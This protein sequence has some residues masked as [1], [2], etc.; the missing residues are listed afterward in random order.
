MMGTHC[1]HVILR[2]IFG[3][4]YERAISLRTYRHASAS[5]QDC[6]EYERFEGSKI[7]NSS[8]AAQRAREG[9]PVFYF[10]RLGLYIAVTIVGDFVRRLTEKNTP[11][12]Y[13]MLPNDTPQ[14]IVLCV[15]HP[16]DTLTRAYISGKF[17][18]YFSQECHQVYVE[19]TGDYFIGG[20]FTNAET[21]QNCARR[22][23]GK[24]EESN[25]V[26]WNVTFTLTAEHSYDLPVEQQLGGK[27][28]GV[29]FYTHAFLPVQLAELIDSMRNAYV[30]AKK[31]SRGG[32][33]L[34]DIASPPS[35]A[36]VSTQMPTQMPTQ[37]PTQ[38]P[39]QVST[40][41]PTQMP[42]QVTSYR[43]RTDI[44]TDEHLDSM[45][46]A[47][48]ADQHTERSSTHSPAFDDFTPPESASETL[49]RLLAEIS[50]GPQIVHNTPVHATAHSSAQ[51]SMHTPVHS[52]VHATAHSSAHLSSHGI[53]APASF[54]PAPY[55][56]PTIEPVL[57]RPNELIM[58]WIARNPPDLMACAQYYDIYVAMKKDTETSRRNFDGLV[59]L[60]GFRKRRIRRE[61]TWVSNCALTQHLTM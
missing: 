41:M 6:A 59:E 12:I 33:N 35:H 50:S 56:P 34:P 28:F 15:K 22:F 1:S 8:V 47:A 10:A 40:Q 3:D 53:P 38:M 24:L 51:P 60:S 29:T 37:I 52:S 20:M 9:Y 18:R 42:V 27:S 16:L 49:D 13:Y 46:S 54:D 45:Y 48:F 4:D 23:I 2:R 43:N 58:R 57:R 19:D 26:K 5:P 14:P 7:C 32:S 55:D 61:W 11:N 21:A 36:Q 39:V 44:Y 25:G 31:N 17:R 30:E